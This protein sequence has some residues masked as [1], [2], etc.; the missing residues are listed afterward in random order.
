MAAD[1]WESR[2]IAYV[3]IQRFVLLFS[4]SCTAASGASSA[5][6]L[7]A[8]VSARRGSAGGGQSVRRL[9]VQLFNAISSSD[10]DK[11][12]EAISLG[13]NPSAIQSGWSRSALA[14]AL[15]RGDVAM[16]MM[17][18]D[19][20]ANV[21]RVE[22]SGITMLHVATSQRLDEAVQRLLE[23]GVD[24]NLASKDGGTP[25]TMA[26]QR[27]AVRIGE[28][29]MD[30]GA[31]I[32]HEDKAQDQPI[33]V[34]AQQRAGGMLS[35]LL[36]RGARIDAGNAKGMTALHLAAREGWAEGVR[37][38]IDAGANVKMRDLQGRTALHHLAEVFDAQCAALLMQAGCSLQDKDAH[39]MTPAERAAKNRQ[40]RSALA[41]IALGADS[42]RI[43][44]RAITQISALHA[45]ARLGWAEQILNLLAMGADPNE[46][47]ARKSVQDV[48]IEG[49]HD[50]AL[51]AWQGWMMRRKMI[52]IAQSAGL[53][54]IA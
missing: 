4:T 26:A 15:N 49:G 32:H 40:R 44:A 8:K 3:F 39:D 52:M 30:A 41:F 23:E 21:H 31:N 13:A 27:N 25:L 28:M 9:N 47:R 53:K 48:L 24:P 46:Q 54:A 50:D 38:L 19:C 43:V 51:R 42:S 6:N 11:A 16:A 45:A 22:G 7:P 2:Q 37:L 33:H 14:T 17:L 1:M 35:L 36:M 5:S 12:V 18:I 34:A 10:M 29:L 20:G